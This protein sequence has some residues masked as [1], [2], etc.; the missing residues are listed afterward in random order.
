MNTASRTYYF[1]KD[2]LPKGWS[3]PL[4]R[5]VLDAA[6]QSAGVTTVM[7][8]NYSRLRGGSL[9]GG[10]YPWPMRVAF[11]PDSPSSPTSGKM[12]ITVYAVPSTQRRATE[13]AIESKLAAICNWIRRSE[14]APLGWRMTEHV[15]TVEMSDEQARLVDRVDL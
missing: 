13:L 7:F 14:S 8:V 9:K 12:D 6:L 4:R 3:Y 1:Y 11:M 15:V 10:R 2:R 5:S